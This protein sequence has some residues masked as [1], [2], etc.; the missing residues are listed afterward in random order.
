MSVATTLLLAALSAPWPAPPPSTA[1]EEAA[2]LL[3]QALAGEPRI[4]AVQRAAAARAGIGR[5]EAEGWRRRSRLAA[6]VPRLS[7]DYRHDERSYRVTG[8]SAGAEVD[9]IRSSPGDTVSVRLDWDLDGLVLGR[10]EL[11][12]ASA[13]QRVAAGRQRAVE[14]ASHLY[15]ERV[16]L[17]LA[18]AASPPDDAR[19]RAEVELELEEVT[20]ELDALTGLYGEEAP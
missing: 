13:A 7:A 14:R 15:Y 18:L 20:A 3:G 6:L 19:K 4:E 2:R 12:A 9:Y 1:R 8:L 11:E 16:R 17:R 10:R 5:E